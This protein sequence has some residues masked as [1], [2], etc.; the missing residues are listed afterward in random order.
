[1]PRSWPQ[2][3]GRKGKDQKDSEG[4]LNESFLLGLTFGQIFEVGPKILISGAEH[5]VIT[6]QTTF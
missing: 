4:M 2:V 5:V 1:V 3:L 6:H